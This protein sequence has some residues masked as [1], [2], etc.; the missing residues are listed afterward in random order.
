MARRNDITTNDVKAIVENENVYINN[1]PKITNV[2]SVYLTEEIGESKN[3]RDLFNLLR[4][5]NPEDNFIIYMNNFGG[6]VSTGVDIINAMKACNGQ[7]FTCMTGPCYSMAPLITLAAQKVFIEED[8]FMMFHDYSTGAEGKGNEIS[9]RMEH[10]K[11]HFDN[12]FKKIVNG[13][14]TKQEIKNVL[15]GQDLYLGKEEIIKRLKRIKKLG[16]GSMG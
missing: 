1:N 3:Y 7:V 15:K 16:N 14:L 2:F 6:Y 12:M 8:T 13:F 4:E 11:P 9:I 10:E 5:A